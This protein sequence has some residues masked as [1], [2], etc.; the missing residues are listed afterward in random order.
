LKGIISMSGEKIS[1]E[2]EIQKDL[3]KMLEYATVKY[4]LGDTSKA[5][6]VILDFTSKDGDWNEIFNQIRC[7][8]CGGQNGWDKEAHESKK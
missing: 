4:R 5:L 6:R 7:N 1:V 8:R 2:F 3:V